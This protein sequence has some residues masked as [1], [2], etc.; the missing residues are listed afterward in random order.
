MLGCEAIATDL[1]GY[2]GGK[3][4]GATAVSVEIHLRSCEHCRA[5][6][7]ELHQLDAI[8][9]MAL[10]EIKPSAGFASRFANRLAAEMAEEE[11]A[12][13]RSSWLSW[14]LQPWLVPAAAAAVLGAVVFS[15]WLATE[16][17]PKSVVPSLPA[18]TSGV[19]S[20]EKP[21]DR[22]VA[23]PAAPAPKTTVT[24]AV[25]SKDVPKDLI[26]RPELF[27]DYAIIRDL[28]MLES[29]DSMAEAG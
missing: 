25:A 2:V 15:P 22:G 23:A 18:I 7:R 9:S 6:I 10:P 29:G 16:R 24:T 14:L 27:V 26:Q 21:A 4:D 11:Q 13:E 5:E 19:A 3:L 1:P 28:D 8:L 12:R 17:T 20:V